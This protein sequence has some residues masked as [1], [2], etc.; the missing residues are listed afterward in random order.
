MSPRILPVILLAL[1]TAHAERPVDFRRDVRPILASHCYDC[2]G[3][4]KPKGGLRLTS[5]ANALKGGESETPAFVAG[6]GAD[7]ELI[8]R[9]ASH[10]AD[11]P[12]LSH[13]RE[14]LTS[15]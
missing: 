5:R 15:R 4:Q 12:V 6:K 9:V 8:L 3:D 10:D 14:D 1:A 11:E 13:E 2:H 7:S